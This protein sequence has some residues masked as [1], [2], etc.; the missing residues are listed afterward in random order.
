MMLS[1]IEDHK[2]NFIDLGF[3]I[4]SPVIGEHNHY[5]DNDYEEKDSDEIYISP[6]SSILSLSPSEF[7][8]IDCL[9]FEISTQSENV[10]IISECYEALSNLRS[11][12]E[13]ELGLDLSLLMYDDIPLMSLEEASEVY[14]SSDWEAL[15]IYIHK[16]LK[17]SNGTL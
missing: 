13:S 8:I 4:S 2:F 3:D 6:S 7:L 10:E 15:S 14:G 5:V 9:S 1:I 12:L 17:S 11:H 16:P